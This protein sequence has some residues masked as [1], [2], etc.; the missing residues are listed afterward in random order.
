MSA[1]TV[2]SIEAATIHV[3]LLNE[4]T[5]VWRPVKAQRLSDTT[6]QIADEPVPEDETWSFQPG[7]IVVAEARSSKDRAL[8]A[9]ARASHFDDRSWT[10]RRK[11]G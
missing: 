9:V 1:A 4:G 3:R 8:V 6:Y 5:D 10:D 11:A 7:E 2:S